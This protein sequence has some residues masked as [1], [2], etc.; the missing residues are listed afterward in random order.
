MTPLLTTVLASLP[1]LSAACARP[2]DEHVLQI[3]ARELWVG[4][5][6]RLENALL[7]VA[8]GRIRSVST[9]RAPDVS[10]P[11]YEHDGVVTAGLIACQSESGAA[12]ELY[13]DTR[14]VLAAAHTVDVFQPEH[15][16]FERARAAGITTVVLSPGGENLVGGI[17]C[18]VKTAGGRVLEPRSALALSFSGA[19]L[20]RTNS[21]QFF[22]FGAAEDEL[23]SP[24]DG[25]PEQPGRSARG[26]REPT[27]YSGAV[28]TLQRLFASG[29]EPYA[30]AERGVLPVTLDA[31]DR[32]EIVRAALFARE[33]G[34]RGAVRG[35]PLA[36]DPEVLAELKKSGLG[37]IHGPWS[38]E[39]TRASLESLPRLSEAGLPVAFA[40]DAPVHS[41]EDLRLFAAR[42]LSVGAPRD[43]VWKAL[44]V[45]AAAIAGVGE[46]VGRLAEG[47]QADFV[48]WSG[49]PLDLRS[50]AQRVY[51]DG[52]LAWSEPRP[53]SPR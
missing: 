3:R 38:A 31:W 37:V 47:M 7:V 43:A 18:A 51:V 29:A 2:A 8:D 4:D 28:A 26:T 1:V 48:L 53:S 39:Q 17:A 36:G 44:T 6:Q 16:D 25:G 34:L 19:A 11:L 24:A 12:G 13:D 14:A 10:V 23:Q 40:L 21:S 32:H 35:A 9:G 30:S 42:A 5:G 49:D 33:H 52:A 41:P 27:S 20:G 22:F 46:R 15:R 45:D 50:R